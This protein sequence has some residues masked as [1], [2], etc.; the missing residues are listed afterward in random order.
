VLLH[1]IDTLNMEVFKKLQQQTEA[2]PEI[3]A[4]KALNHLLDNPEYD[5]L[6]SIP[7]NEQVITGASTSVEALSIAKYKIE[8]REKR[9][10]KFEAPGGIEMTSVNPRGI[11]KAI[12]MINQSASEI[13]AGGDAVVVIAESESVEGYSRICYKIAHKERTPRGR[14]TMSQEIDIHNKFYDIIAGLESSTIGVPKPYYYV[15]MSG[16]K[17]IAMERL[18]ARSVDD[19]LR[20]FGSLPEWF[21]DEQVDVLCDDL[22]HALDACHT[23]G[24]YHRDLH[25]GNIMVTQSEKHENVDKLGYLID[26]GLSGMGVEDMDPYKKEVT[27][28]T[29]TYSEDYGRIEAVR[30]RLKELKQR[31]S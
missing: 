23:Q 25:L 31:R 22:I 26:F 18:K 11:R 30:N 10:L 17:I 29:F 3:Q 20:G 19:L 6:N 13:G 12:E 16:Q 5:F 15:E 9:T 24:L 14:N 8:E 28:R 1:Y 7:A 4:E 2:S 21:N 27:G